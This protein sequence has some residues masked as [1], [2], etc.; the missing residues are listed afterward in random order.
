MELVEAENHDEESIIKACK[1]AKI[2]VHT[3]SPFSLSA[4]ADELI[5]AAVAGTKA[6]MKGAHANKAKVVLL[7]SLV[8]MIGMDAVSDKDHPT[9]GMFGET[10]WTDPEKVPSGYVKSKTYAEKA[11][12]DYLNSLPENEKFPMATINPGFIYGP[13]LNTA[14]F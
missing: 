8:A 11:A 14:Q 7:S 6:A 2:I 13:N 5:S 9:G 12:W 10:D 1:G 3:A 4:P